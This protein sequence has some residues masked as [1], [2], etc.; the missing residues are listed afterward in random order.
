MHTIISFQGG[1][2]SH[3]FRILAVALAARNKLAITV[4]I[5]SFFKFRSIVCFI[6]RNLGSNQ[7]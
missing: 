4:I 3:T 2:W 5:V 7:Q 6:A 1:N